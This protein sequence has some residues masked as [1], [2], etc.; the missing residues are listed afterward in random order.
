MST[1]DIVPSDGHDLRILCLDKRVARHT[2]SSGYDRIAAYLN[3]ENLKRPDL[4]NGVGRIAEKAWNFF[5]GEDPY[6][7]R[8]GFEDR[9]AEER[10]FWKAILT[11]ADVTFMPYGEEQLGTLLRRARY[12]SGPLVA[13]FH[14]PFARESHR[15][16]KIRKNA[17][18]NLAG[19]FVLA[20]SEVAPFSEWLGENKVMFVPHGIDID[21]FLPGV[22]NTGTMARFVFVGRHLR[23]YEIAHIVADRCAREGLDVVFDVVLPTALMSFFT[24]CANIQ[25]HIDISEIELIRL[26][27]DSDALFLPLLDGTANNAILEALACGTPVIST[28]IGG[29]PDYVDDAS[30]WLLRPRDADEAFDRH[31]LGSGLAAESYDRSMACAMHANPGA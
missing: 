23:D 28:R 13:T 25:P 30:G 24:G 8:Y 27:Q 15:F 7:L 6:L 10:A 2:T 12:L 17:V 9:I 20:S 26:Y 5:R 18:R 21:I 29:I 1:V 4:G 22:G 16:E 14:V 31:R 19:V 3:G 11:R